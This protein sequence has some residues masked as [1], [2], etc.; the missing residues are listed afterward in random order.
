MGRGVCEIQEEGIVC[1]SLIVNIFN[2]ALCCD[3]NVSVRVPTADHRARTK[4][5]TTFLNRLKQLGVTDNVRYLDNFII[6]DPAEGRH[7]DHSVSKIVIEA[8]GEWAARDRF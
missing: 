8:V 4:S 2:S 1:F 6:F 3:R 5:P 7:V